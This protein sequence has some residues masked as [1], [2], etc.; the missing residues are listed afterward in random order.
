VVTHSSVSLFFSA[1]LLWFFHKSLLLSQT[2]G[3]CLMAVCLVHA[4]GRW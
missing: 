3:L 4:W 2:V 1:G